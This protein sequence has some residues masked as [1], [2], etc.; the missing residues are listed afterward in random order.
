MASAG[1]IT[2]NANFRPMDMVTR[3]EAIKMIIRVK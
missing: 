1:Y 3:A 2:K